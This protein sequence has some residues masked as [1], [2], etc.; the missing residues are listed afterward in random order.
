MATTLNGLERDVH[1]LLG[2]PFDAVD[3]E[4]AAQRLREAARARRPC[5][6]ATP[7]LNFAV[8]CRSDAEFRDAVIAA[9]LSLADG[10]PLV[11]V[12]RLLG[13]PIP[14]RV[15][16]SDLFERLRREREP[17]LLVYFF[18][19]KDG[20]AQAA[21]QR[22]DAEEGGLACAGFE[23]PGFGTLEDLSRPERLARINAS[24]ADLLVV[25]VS[26][27]KGQCWIERNRE[28]LT[29]PVMSNLGAT[30]NFTAGTVERAPA[31]MRAA[32]LEW[33]WRAMR[34][35][36]LWRRY[37]RD[38]LA[39]LGLLATRVVPLAIALR[40]RRPDPGALRDATIEW[41]D[42]AGET[43][44]RLRGPWANGNLERLRAVF[45]RAACTPGMLRLDLGEATY[46]DTGFLGLLVL[47]Y[48][49]RRRARL[50]FVCEPVSSRLRRLIVNSCGEYLLHRPGPRESTSAVYAEPK[51]SP[52]R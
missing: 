16:G 49:V 24:E 9:D 48:G 19:G 3:L 14:A 38:G 13:A 18:G 35:P 17:R 1:C 33:L 39:F 28:R 40:L 10:M 43:V 37:L 11:W 26:A 36:A 6:M 20:V 25:S 50:P 34:E 15:A 52:W 12:A 22:L 42:K 23:S 32:G 51:A 47:L 31:W 30:V 27:R 7:N 45:A 8:A 41:R 44:V 4:G 2:L 29:V 46:G 5:A 21:C